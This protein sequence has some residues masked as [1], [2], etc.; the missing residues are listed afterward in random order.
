MAFQPI[1]WPLERMSL[2]TSACC[3]LFMAGCTCMTASNRSSLMSSHFGIV[4]MVTKYCCDGFGTLIA[5]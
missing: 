4:A 1:S 3:S 2:T 5:L